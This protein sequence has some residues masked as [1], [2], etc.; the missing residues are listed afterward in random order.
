VP[1]HPIHG[2]DR[3]LD[4]RDDQAME[5]QTDPP[6]NAAEARMRAWLDLRV[7]MLELLAELEYTALMLKLGVMRR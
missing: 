2:V 1:G 6:T 4:H 7:S 5:P 3:A